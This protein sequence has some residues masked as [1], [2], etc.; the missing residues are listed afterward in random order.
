MEGQGKFSD[1][2]GDL[3]GQLASTEGQRS[4]P[5]NVQKK[6][7]Q[8][9]DVATS[10]VNAPLE[11]TSGD[12]SG[13]ADRH[14]RSATEMTEQSEAEEATSQRQQRKSK[15][16]GAK[17]GERSS[18]ASSSASSSSAGWYGNQSSSTNFEQSDT[19]QEP[20]GTQDEEDMQP[21]HNQG[22]RHSEAP[23]IDSDP[24]N[25]AEG[26]AIAESA[27]PMPWQSATPQRKSMPVP[28][29]RSQGPEK[30]A[31]R[32]A[33]QQQS[34]GA[35]ESLE[36]PASSREVPERA[37]KGGTLAKFSGSARG[38]RAEQQ[39]YGWGPGLNADFHAESPSADEPV[40]GSGSEG[41]E[42]ANSATEGRAPERPR[43]AP[44]RPAMD[45]SVS[46]GEGR[47][48]DNSA[49]ALQ[50]W[51]ETPG[52]NHGRSTAAVAQPNRQATRPRSSPSNGAAAQGPARTQGPVRPRPL[53]AQTPARSAAGEPDDQDPTRAGD[54]AAATGCDGAQGKA[55]YRTPRRSS[56]RRDGAPDTPAAQPQHI[57]Y[58][59]AYGFV[60]PGDDPV[61]WDPS[62]H[63]STWL[64]QGDELRRLTAVQG[65]VNRLGFKLG[66]KEEE[67]AHPSYWDAS[68]R[69]ARSTVEDEQDAELAHYKRSGCLPRQPL[70]EGV[71]IAIQDRA[72]AIVLLE[73]RA[74]MLAMRSPSGPCEIATADE[75][76]QTPQERSGRSRE[77]TWWDTNLSQIVPMYR[78]NL[79]RRDGVTAEQWNEAISDDRDERN[80]YELKAHWLR[81][82]HRAS[83]E[84]DPAKLEAFQRRSA[85]YWHQQG[86]R[87]QTRRY[88]P[89]ESEHGPGGVLRRFPN[90][91]G[92]HPAA[93]LNTPEEPGYSIDDREEEEPA[94]AAQLPITAATI[95]IRL[96]AAGRPRTG[97]TSLAAA[98]AVLA[99]LGEEN[100]QHE[101]N[102]DQ[103]LSH[104]RT[105]DGTTLIRLLEVLDETLMAASKAHLALKVASAKYYPDDSEFA[106][107]VLYRARAVQTNSKRALIILAGL[108][109]KATY[110]AMNEVT[111]YLTAYVKAES[112]N[113]LS[114]EPEQRLTVSDNDVGVSVSGIMRL[115]GTV[116]NEQAQLV[117]Q[118]GAG[119]AQAHRAITYHL[120][121]VATE[122][123]LR[124]REAQTNKP[125]SALRETTTVE[126]VRNVGRDRDPDGDYS[127]LTQFTLGA[128]HAMSLVSQAERDRAST[129]LEQRTSRAL[130]DASLSLQ[131]VLKKVEQYTMAR[132]ALERCDSEAARQKSDALIKVGIANYCGRDQDFATQFIRESISG[133]DVTAQL[134]FATRWISNLNDYT[135]MRQASQAPS[136]TQK[137]RVN[138]NAV[139]AGAAAAPTGK[140]KDQALGP[141][142]RTVLGGLTPQD[143][144]RAEKALVFLIRQDGELYDGCPHCGD[145]AGHEGKPLCSEASRK[146]PSYHLNAVTAIDAQQCT[147]TVKGE[148]RCFNCDGLGHFARECTATKAKAAGG[149]A[150]GSGREEGARGARARSS[151][152]RDDYRSERRDDRRSAPHDDGRPCSRCKQTGHHPAT[153]PKPDDRP[154]SDDRAWPNDR[155]CYSCGQPGHRRGQ[156]KQQHRS[157]QPR[158]DSREQDRGNR[159]WPS[160]QNR[161]PTAGVGDKAIKQEDIARSVADE[162]R[163]QFR[164]VFA[165]ERALA[166]PAGWPPQTMNAQR[167]VSFHEDPGNDSGGDNASRRPKNSGVGNATNPTAGSR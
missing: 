167:S 147:L 55:P 53:H 92:E 134:A 143:R 104:A 56:S 10:E 59:A 153:C 90:H 43:Q 58:E 23:E 133:Q 155:T 69:D 100:G 33:S 124:A 14:K 11:A 157:E 165:Q 139:E 83:L 99:I 21:D 145:P 54:A 122:K 108:H 117:V 114:T 119:P 142:A 128:P 115:F 97:T 38:S 164:N 132:A 7:S 86:G 26:Q 20:I 57:T 113:K 41:E 64:T 66:R 163:T 111:R 105:R 40:A 152:R 50:R 13:R 93:A 60:Q 25:E 94:A 2:P 116:L 12:G 91:R 123:L 159:G 19:E 154:Q 4:A 22:D 146:N 156:C 42:H 148:M 30:M 47:D 89:H 65:V 49:G 5:A 18:A 87:R 76:E 70:P 130:N 61:Q 166:M 125:Q 28:A 138:V 131:D 72:R 79:P 110:K 32:P 161:Y 135:L 35:R 149:A 126:H 15:D 62:E 162:L 68:H 51:P 3:A 160:N 46:R 78:V 16:G 36:L 1:N 96:A 80:R 29:R 137:G 48:M 144:A 27:E 129:D 98:K 31:K 103:V 39:R 85:S 112:E 151:E 17:S 127:D 109:N 158:A 37:K 9:A 73:T 95:L 107:L 24:N 118:T 8:S 77:D 45:S 106:E 101:S 150:A 44:R 75:A 63:G 121:C 34:G 84:A 74:R 136:G 81:L 102:F 52:F 67:T 140:T 120:Q 141:R 71:P 6:S 82:E 88:V